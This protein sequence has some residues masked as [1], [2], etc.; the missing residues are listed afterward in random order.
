MSLGADRKLDLLGVVLGVVILLS[1][2]LL[3]YSAVSGP[4][5]DRFQ[6][7]DANWS[8]ERVN[9]SHVEVVHAGGDPVRAERIAISVNGRERPTPFEGQ[10]R[11]GD[12][13][14]LTVSPD[15]SVEIAWTGGSG[16]RDPMH[17]EEV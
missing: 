6:P 3:V 8:V 5:E 17:R 13:A 4:A 1:V 14:L 7:P 11:E 10:V 12:A 16:T 9:D 15:Q 2:G